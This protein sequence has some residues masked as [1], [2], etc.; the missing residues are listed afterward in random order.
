MSLLISAFLTASGRAHQRGSLCALGVVLHAGS[1]ELTV[2]ERAEAAP[3]KG[4]LEQ[5]SLQPESSPKGGGRR[6]L[7]TARGG[8]KP[9]G[10][11][12]ISEAASCRGHGLV[13]SLPLPGLNP[14]PLSHSGQQ[15]VLPQA[16][17]PS[18]QKGGS[19]RVAGE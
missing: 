11:S 4:L 5:T 10:M 12:L 14:D 7:R 17:H 18:L 19:S 13:S 1:P 2:G 6:G 16:A 9:L 8:R 15:C 3:D